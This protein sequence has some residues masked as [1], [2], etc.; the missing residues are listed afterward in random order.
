M[1]VPVLQP[2]LMVVLLATTSY[3]SDFVGFVMYPEV[4]HAMFI[5]F[6]LQPR[7]VDSALL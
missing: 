6:F 4:K 1:I 7:A 3:G 5:Y 2:W